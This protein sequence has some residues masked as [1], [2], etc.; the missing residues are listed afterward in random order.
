MDW[1]SNCGTVAVIGRSFGSAVDAG[2]RMRGDRVDNGRS[3]GSESCEVDIIGD[4]G[5]SSISLIALTLT[6]CM[7]VGFFSSMDESD[8]PECSI[9][10]KEVN[11]EKEESDGEDESD[12]DVTISMGAC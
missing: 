2:E 5:K 3:V 1:S 4:K 12:P 8:E 10:G 11:A 6:A 9:D 7:R